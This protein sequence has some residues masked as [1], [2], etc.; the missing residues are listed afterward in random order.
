M[1]I[2][3]EAPVPPPPLRVALVAI[4]P[5]R[6]Q[7]LETIVSAAG[8]VSVERDQ[9][10]VV[11]TDGDLFDAA[12]PPVVSIG[13]RDVG[14]AALL[15]ANANATQIDAGLRAAAAGLSVRHFDNAAPGFHGIDEADTPLLTPREI[16]VLVGIADG[17]S[18][19][20][21]ARRLGISQHTVK[22]H[23][24]ALF[25]KLGAASRAEAVRKGLSQ[26]LLQL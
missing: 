12:G 20:G 17:L 7:R 26:R 2:D 6:R 11:L 1:S 14:Q 16:E 18:N 3:D 24:E 10:D 9:A 5:S 21:V 22:F 13:S 8:H 19:K 4:D 15:P 23:V 25:R